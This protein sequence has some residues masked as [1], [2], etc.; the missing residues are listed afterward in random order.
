M[1][2]ILVID[3][4]S[5][6]TGFLCSILKADDYELTTCHTAE[7]GLQAA[8]EGGWSLIL[9]DVV[10]PGMDGFMLLQELKGA[11]VTR[12]VPVI[13]ITSLADAQYEERGLVLGAVDYVTKPFKPAIIKARVN[14]HIQLYRYQMQFM[15][16]AMVDGLTGVANR[17]R[18]E[19][20]SEA[21]WREAIRFGLPFSICMFD[22]DKFKAYNDTFGHQ[23]GDKVIAA[24]AK[25]ASSFFQRST[26]LFARY[27]GEEFVAVFLGAQ[28]E[29][30][31]EFMK[32]VRQGVED[33]HIQHN[34]PVCPW[35]TVSVGGVT[36]T[37]RLGDNLDTYL[38]LADTMLYDAK[39]F[40][41][42]MV[43]WAGRSGEQWREK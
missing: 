33:L 42:N 6:Q 29:S 11:E 26:D 35:V 5:V 39:R 7:E 15:E 2:R 13:L 28:A 10:M 36:V 9:L 30:A 18:Y 3:D 8:K 25:T 34:S 38:K 1:D 24:V 23:A 37:P 17:R 43:V 4:S 31:F 20:E 12:H 19:E 21:R 16:Q 27:G 41:R 22:I 14:T 32:S 40:G